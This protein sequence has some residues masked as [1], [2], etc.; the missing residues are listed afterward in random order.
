[1]K[2]VTYHY[3]F[4]L[5]LL[6][7]LLLIVNAATGQER[8]MKSGG[9]SE[10]QAEAA[11]RGR[12]Q[13]LK[14]CA[15]CHGP[16]G[17]GGSEG[18]DLMRSSVVRHDVNG[19]LIGEVIRDGRPDKGMP[20]FQFSA[21]QIA[22]VVAFL[23]ERLKQ[24]DLR[25]P[26]RPGAGYSL[27]KLLVGNAAAGRKFFNGAGGCSKCH[28]V[29][30]DLAGIAKKY[31]AADLQARFLYPRGLHQTAT[32]IDS[33]GKQ[34]TGVVRLLTPY[35]IAIQDRAGWYRSW[36]RSAVKVQLSNP[37]AAHRRLISTITDAEMHD[38]FAYLETLK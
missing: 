21:G 14:T 12:S 15:F 37:L 25:S 26:N 27:A 3:V 5:C 29:T 18:P 19:N 10:E 7:G 30:G 2:I 6:A 36:P 33:S 4:V 13:F 1:M 32:V 34:F 9:A 38:M 8:A 11:Q 17:N 24:V 23:H 16:E 22:D 31:P 20:A 35:D 28:S